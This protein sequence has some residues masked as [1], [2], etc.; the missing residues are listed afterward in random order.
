ME[1]DPAVCTRL[2]AANGKSLTSSLDLVFW[3]DFMIN[4]ARLNCWENECQSPDKG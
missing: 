2:R 4:W 1:T 3:V